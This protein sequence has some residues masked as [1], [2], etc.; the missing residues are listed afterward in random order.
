MLEAPKGTPTA[1]LYLE[2]SILPIK[3]EIEIKQLLYLK[4]ILYK[5]TDDLVQLCYREMLKF[6][7]EVNWTNDVLGLGKQYNLSLNDDTV[8][9]MGVKDWKWIVKV[10]GV[11]TLTPVII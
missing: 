4:R 1:A 10:T 8:K 9:N 3:F 2:L 5:E 7:E 11:A 6:S